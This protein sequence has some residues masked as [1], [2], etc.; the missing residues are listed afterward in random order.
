MFS[1]IKNKL[2][3][4]LVVLLLG[5]SFFGYLTVKMGGDA[6]MAATRLTMIGQ[7][8]AD[9]NA[10]M[11]NLRGFQLLASSQMLEGYTTSYTDVN[12]NLDS[13]LAILLSKVNQERIIRLKNDFNAWHESNK[14]RMEIIKQ[15][16]KMVNSEAF[17]KE[18]KAEFDRLT[19]VTQKSAVAFIDILKQ[20]DELWVL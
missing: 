15:Y 17:E 16:G 8:K 18:H 4:M 12:K 3:L 2:M 14:N 7:V 19:S 5:F 13:L 6:K 1:T 9:I 10:C 20:T 11:M